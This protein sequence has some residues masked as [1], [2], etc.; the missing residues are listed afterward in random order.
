MALDDKRKVRISKFLAKCL[1]HE[2]EIAGLTLAPGGWVTVEDLLSGCERAG[3]RLSRQELEEVVATNDKQRFAF[4]EDR[5]RIRAN[6]GHSVEVDLQLE[7]ATP[8]DVL[9]HGTGQKSVTAIMR[10]G[11]Q[12]MSRH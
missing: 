7:P 3:V 10:D 11:L 1:R 8:P 4:D 9:Y 2:P 6:Q 5:M 12:K